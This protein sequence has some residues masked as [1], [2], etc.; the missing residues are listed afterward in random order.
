MNW[1]EEWAKIEVI[2]TWVSIGVIAIAAIFVIVHLIRFW[3]EDRATKR[4]LNKRDKLLA[5]V[6]S[7]IKEGDTVYIKH[8]RHGDITKA[9][10]KEVNTEFKKIFVSWETPLY[11]SDWFYGFT[12]G[13][14]WALTKEE[15]EVKK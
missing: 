15:L 4:R 13:K 2:G 11:M 5:K 3:A 7:K 6:F 1:L 14:D 8:Y 10:C 12:Y 9:T